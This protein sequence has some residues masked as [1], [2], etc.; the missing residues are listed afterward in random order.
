MSQPNG[1]SQGRGR[2]FRK[3]SRKA[4]ALPGATRDARAAGEIGPDEE[5]TVI[6]RKVSAGRVTALTGIPPILFRL[7][8]DAESE[9]DLSRDE[10]LQ[11][12]RELMLENPEMLNASI[13]QQQNQ[14]RAII[15]LGVV[16]PPIPYRP[17]TTAVD[18]TALPE[19]LEEDPETVLFEDLD[20]DDITY[21]HNAIVS[22]GSMDIA[23]LDDGSA[24]QEGRVS[25]EGDRFL[26]ERPPDPVLTDGEGVRPEPE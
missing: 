22:F 17:F 12:R 21:L 23:A 11:R 13:E 4:L 15:H 14:L 18:S 9:K 2:L 19:V 24:S 16:D 1:K 26:S 10:A 6:I 5:I 25:D 3:L 20:P 8:I 7:A